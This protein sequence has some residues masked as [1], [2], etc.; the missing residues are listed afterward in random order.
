MVI[1]EGIQM[2]Y[3]SSILQASHLKS[4]ENHFHKVKFQAHKVSLMNNI[5]N[6]RKQQYKLYNVI[7]WLG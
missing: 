4:I 2:K 6:F 1:K 7:I 5:T 3:A